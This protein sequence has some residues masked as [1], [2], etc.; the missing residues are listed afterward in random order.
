LATRGDSAQHRSANG[1]D[2][3][4]GA[5]EFR[6]GSITHRLSDNIR[7]EA[8]LEELVLRPDRVRLDVWRVLRCV[9]LWFSVP[10]DLRGRLLDPA[11]LARLESG[12]LFAAYDAEIRSALGVIVG[13]MRPETATANRMALACLMAAD[14]ATGQSAYRT[15]IGFAAGAALASDNPSYW[16]VAELAVIR[17]R[18]R[19]ESDDPPDHRRLVEWRTALE[20]EIAH[21]G[22]PGAT[23]D[24]PSIL[25][26][27]RRKFRKALPDADA[28]DDAP[29]RRTGA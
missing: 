7:P 11:G 5:V 4:A 13:A 8:V 1:D 12:I 16:L 9:Q 20:E 2:S 22:G 3:Q 6:P 29:D 26:S 19:T 24:G 27:I 17:Y 15:M 10:A 23:R 21:A 14:W 18:L 28:I 25:R